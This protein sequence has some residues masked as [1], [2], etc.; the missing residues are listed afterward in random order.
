LEFPLA[1]GEQRTL[2]LTAETVT[3]RPPRNI[4][5][6]VVRC[7]TEDG[8]PLPGCD[9]KLMGEQGEVPASSNQAERQ[10]FVGAPGNYELSA[11]YPGFVI[12]SRAATIQP[13]GLDGRVVDVE[14]EV[15]LSRSK[16]TR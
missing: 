4:G 5:M 11:A 14:I 7:Y 6:L 9:V 3:P 8:V 16:H 1:E 10:T 13:V 2:D 12:A 15:M